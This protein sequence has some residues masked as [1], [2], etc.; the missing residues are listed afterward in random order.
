MVQ[1]LKKQ[2]FFWA[3]AFIVF[4]LLVTLFRSVLLPFVLGGAVA[5]LLNPLVQKLGKA[6]FSRR[7]AALLILASFLAFV[8]VL[9]L[10]ALPTILDEIHDLSENIPIYIEDFRKALDPYLE[11]FRHLLGRTNLNSVN[12]VASQ[13]AGTALEISGKVLLGLYAGG[14]VLIHIVTVLVVMPIVAYF[15][16]KEWPR[17]TAWVTGLLPR[18]HK[19]TIM[20][21]FRDIDRRLSGFVRG[22]LSA[23]LILGIGY[24]I[25]LTMVG[26]KYGFLIGLGSGLLSIIPLVGSSVGLVVGV[27]VAFFQT[28]GDWSFV[29]LIGGIFIIGQLIEGNLLTPLMVGESTGLHPLWI[30]FALMA[31]GSLFGILGMLLAVPVTVVISVLSSFVIRQYKA[32]S[33]Y[34]G[35]K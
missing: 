20:G 2:A 18:Q 17:I 9:C 27:T 8:L 19:E 11:H 22:Q 7:I 6:G 28:G 13:H 23:M 34:T 26:L 35:Q 5:Y 16:M 12:E 3:G 31:G 24:A 25:A 30:F 33:Y 4:V 1:T 29:A 10:A 32:S 21:L 14:Q 15:M